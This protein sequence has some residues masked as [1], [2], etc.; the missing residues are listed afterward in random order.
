MNGIFEGGQTHFEQIFERAAAA[1]ENALTAFNRAV[2]N[3]RFL[4]T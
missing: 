4:R 3:T 2:E 1:L